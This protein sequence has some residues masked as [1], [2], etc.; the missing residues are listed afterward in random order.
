MGRNQYS[1]IDLFSLYYDIQISVHCTVWIKKWNSFEWKGLA[2]SNRLPY[3]MTIIRRCS[4]VSVPRK[5][6]DCVSVTLQWIAVYARCFQCTTPVGPR[7]YFENWGR[8]RF[9][10]GQVRLPNRSSTSSQYFLGKN[11]Y[12]PRPSSYIQPVHAFGAVV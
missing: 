5:R 6:R 10:S 12:I 3:I 4:A 11:H 7:T 8:C 1:L 9:V 2:K